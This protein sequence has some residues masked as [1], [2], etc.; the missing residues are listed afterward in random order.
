MSDTDKI[1]IVDFPSNVMHIL[2]NT[3]AQHYLPGIIKEKQRDVNCYQISLVGH[4]WSYQSGFNLHARSALIHVLKVATDMGWRLVVSADVSA[5]YVSQKDGPSYPID[6]HTWYFVHWPGWIPNTE[7][8]DMEMA[9]SGGQTK[10]YNSPDQPPPS[11]N[12]APTFL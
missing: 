2:R 8:S 12:E 1:R 9:V 5:K 10:P 3:I 6:V 7:T 4:P 11:Y